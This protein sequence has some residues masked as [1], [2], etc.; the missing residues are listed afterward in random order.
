MN[1]KR[2]RNQV[3]PPG[4]DNTLVRVIVDGQ[5]AG[6]ACACR[7]ESGDKVICWVTQLVVHRDN[8]RRGL[9]MAL[10]K[11]LRRDSDGTYGIASSHPA[12]ILALAKAM[13]S[14]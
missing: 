12:A 5:L 2:L 8:R 14:E 6:H 1:E 10:L 13:G 3:L 9:A 7:W 4:A 11:E